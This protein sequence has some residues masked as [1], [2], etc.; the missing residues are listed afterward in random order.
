[1]SVIMFCLLAGRRSPG[2]GPTRPFCAICC[3][4]LYDPAVQLSIKLTKL[5]STFVIMTP[6]NYPNIVTLVAL[7]KLTVILIIRQAASMAKLHPFNTSEI[8]PVVRMVICLTD[9]PASMLPI[10]ALSRVLA[11]VGYM[12]VRD[13]V[14]AASTALQTCC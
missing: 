2:Q 8:F 5:M 11:V 7:H 6:V 13:V 14:I 3:C 9:M 4:P 12:P 10:P 1:M